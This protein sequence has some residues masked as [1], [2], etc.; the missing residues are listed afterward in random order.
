ME[1]Q[2]C[3]NCDGIGQIVD[4]QEADGL[5]ATCTLCEGTGIIQEQDDVSLDNG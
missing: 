4:A 2:I 5:D 1:D 3:G